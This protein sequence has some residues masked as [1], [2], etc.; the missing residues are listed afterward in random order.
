MTTMTVGVFEIFLLRYFDVRDVR[1][2]PRCKICVFFL[3][4][5]F[6]T[7]LNCSLL[8][9]FRDKLSVPSSG[10]K[11]SRLYR[12]VGEKLPFYAA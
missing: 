10:V 4:G 11:K 5:G 3:G 12:N 8:P 7:A 9:T 2:P 1:R 6:Y